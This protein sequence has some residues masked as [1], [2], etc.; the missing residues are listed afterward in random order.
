M[1]ELL[2]ARRDFLWQTGGG[3][4]GGRAGGGEDNVAVDYP[5]EHVGV[6]LDGVGVEVVDVE[7]IGRSHPTADALVPAAVDSRSD[8]ANVDVVRCAA[9]IITGAALG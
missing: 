7:I 4:A 6:P 1:P 8:Y 2:Q 3:F 9:G 5:L